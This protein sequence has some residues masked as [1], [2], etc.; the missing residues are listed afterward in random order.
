[1]MVAVTGVSGS[2]KSTL[3]HEVIYQ[4]LAK[5]INRDSAGSPDE[6][7][8]WGLAPEKL[9]C[10]KV[11]QAESAQGRWFWWINRPSAARRARIR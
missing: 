6:A 8:D 10:R 2:G 11:E 7:E 5:R 3:V 9:T 1:M 4:N